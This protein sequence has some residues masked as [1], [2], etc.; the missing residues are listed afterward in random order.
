MKVLL[1]I[2]LVLC[3]ALSVNAVRL[4]THNKLPSLSNMLPPD[5]GDTLRE[6]GLSSLVVIGLDGIVWLESGL[7]LKPSEA[8][9]IINLFKNPK[10]VFAS[11]VTV[12]G[13][14]YK[15]SKGD[16]SSIIGKK[17]ATGVAIVKANTFIILSTY[18]KKM[19]TD[20]EAAKSVKMTADL[21]SATGFETLTKYF[22]R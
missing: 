22:K 8:T 2:C 10:K 6:A 12:G 11:G 7:K 18:D 19:N 3:L 15:G 17:G 4:R 5:F 21:F 9:A 16:K 1:S 20:D 13:V 14:K